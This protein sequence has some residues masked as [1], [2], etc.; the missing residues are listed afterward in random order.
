[1]IMEAYAA[2]LP[3][4]GHLLTYRDVT[5]DA[6]AA[7]ALRDQTEFSERLVHSSAMAT[8]VLDPGHRVLF[9]NQACE[10]LTGKAATAMV[11]TRDHWQAFYQEQR[12]CL[13]DLV[14]DGDAAQGASYYR[15]FGSSTLTTD[16]LHGEGWYHGLG[17][18]DRYLVF[19]AAPIRNHRGE[20]VAAVE[21]LQDLTEL[22]RT[23]EARSLL[24]A[25]VEQA[26]EAIVI[27][28][29]RG[30]IEYIN[31]AFTTITGYAQEEVLG[32]HPSLL[33][34]GVQDRE[35]FR[36]LEQ[37]LQAGNVWKGE[38]VN[39][40]KDGDLYQEESTI[41]PVRDP[42]GRIRHYVSVHRDVTAEREVQRRAAQGQRLESLG[43]LAG[44]IAH[45]FNNILAG[46]MGFTELSL[47]GVPAGGPLHANLT[48]I[49]HGTERARD[50]VAQILAFS[51]TGAADSEAAVPVALA[52]LIEETMEFLRATL[53]P[54][55]ALRW[56]TDGAPNRVL[57]SPS[58]VYQVLLNLCTNAG[59]AMGAKGGT[60]EVTVTETVG[61]GSPLPAGGTV[62]LSVGDTGPGIAPENLDRIFEPFFTTKPV[63]QGTGMGLA[64]A[65]G[66]VHAMGGEV[67][68]WS[69]LGAGTRFDVY[70]PAAANRTVERPRPVAAPLAPGH[71]RVLVVDDEDP[72]AELER[73]VL[74][75]LGYR[76]VA[77]GDGEEG[78]RQFR[79]DPDSF[80][81]VLTDYSMPGMNGLDMI[82]QMHE[83][84]PDLP[85]VLCTGDRRCV[86]PGLAKRLNI[87]AVLQKPMSTTQLG[88][89]VASALGPRD[90]VRP[91]PPGAG[92]AASAPG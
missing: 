62:C 44:G 28:D 57:G 10:R 27:T 1:V 59:Q 42:A 21:T 86:D 78:L 22:K 55:V 5:E 33:R 82:A 60:L 61:P 26:A 80:D 19:D 81:L 17:G 32:R 35:F 91:S 4:G 14:I 12:P 41:S 74:E 53:P 51:H 25:A 8:F 16:G 7:Q 65:H 46:I 50:L 18:C 58:R 76:V 15:V 73:Q 9:W 48:R 89:A 24:A 54:T 34:S 36:A 64:V 40:T 69:E 75:Q 52:P 68:V 63:G 45:D 30:C 11:G 29:V 71:G 23:E 79:A 84:R 49:L 20:L 3:A 90:P 13:A 70:L 47:D 37:T 2:S 88:D 38:L 85:V 67:R 66:I 39:R 87:R 6:R 92:A 77:T 83:L 72:V 56:H 43:T 31:P